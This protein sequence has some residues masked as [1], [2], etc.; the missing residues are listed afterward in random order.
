[1]EFYLPPVSLRGQLFPKQI[2]GTELK[3]TVFTLWICLAAHN[4]LLFSLA[5]QL[6]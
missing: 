3:N 1:M 2:L 6:S 5:E 4:I